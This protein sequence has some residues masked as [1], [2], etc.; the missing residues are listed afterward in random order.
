VTGDGPQ[1]L[2]PRIPTA[3]RVAEIDFPGLRVG[4]AE[5]DEGPTGCTVIALDRIALVAIDVR[6]GIPG[7]Y[8]GHARAAEA[9][10]LA[11]GSV[12]GFE[13]IA[14]VAAELYAQRGSDPLLLPAVTGG[15]IY[16]FAPP[17]RT[18]AHPDGE[19]G[20]AALRAA[21]PGAV[22]LGA[23][24]AARSATCGKLGQAGW[25]EP[26]GQGAA[27][28]RIGDVRV[29][30]FVVCNALGVVVDRQGRVARGNRNPDTGERT[31]MSADDMLHGR[32]RQ[33][34]R[35]GKR[36]ASTST[37]TTLTVVVTDAQL[38]ETDLAV[39]SRQV[40]A[41]LARA[42]HPV[43]ASGDGDA[44]WFLTT[45]AVHDPAVSATALGAFA[46]DLVWDAVL[47]GVDAPT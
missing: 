1:A 7:I 28:G 9:V 10:C 21:V 3:S 40:H 6:G 11:G 31:Y 39:L 2:A 23:V 26:G 45:N 24:G 12:L 19:L 47:A 25:A 33:R 34:A 16:D 5:Y 29:V 32:E 46:S 38:G 37:A 15:V 18:G 41:S 43:H 36:A 44:L 35:F 30:A 20:R 27:S 8:H 13:A 14:G 42:I 22:P 17:G 4:V